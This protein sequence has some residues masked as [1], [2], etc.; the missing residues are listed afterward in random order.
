MEEVFEEAPVGVNAKEA[1][2]DSEEDRKMEKRV[3]SEMVELDAVDE[4]KVAEERMDGERKAPEDE[5]DEGYPPPRCGRRNGLGARKAY[6][7]RRRGDQAEP[8]EAG[9]IAGG[10]GGPLP[11]EGVPRRRFLR[12]GALRRRRG[13]ALRGGA[14]ALLDPLRFGIV[15]AA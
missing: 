12:G 5:R 11:A 6:L 1:L 13:G 8:A 14:A 7:V 9:E 3:G 4:K 2:T 10:D 15:P